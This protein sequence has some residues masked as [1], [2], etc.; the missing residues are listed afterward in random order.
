MVV[1]IVPRVVV[2]IAKI[3]FTQSHLVAGFLDPPAQELRNGEFQQFAIIFHANLFFS[4]I[5]FNDLGYLND[6]FRGAGSDQLT[7]IKDMDVIGYVHD[8]PKVVLH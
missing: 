3:L 2:P 6:L 7:E 5:G 4:N 1:E 8:H